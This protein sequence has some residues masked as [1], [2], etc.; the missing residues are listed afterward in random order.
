MELL[1][2]MFVWLFAAY[3]LLRFVMKLLSLCD[4]RKGTQPVYAHR[5]LAVRDCADSLEGL[6][7]SLVWSDLNEEVFVVNLGLDAETKLILQKLKIE[8]PFL[9]I[10]TPQQYIEYIQSMT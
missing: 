3:G 1:F 9:R 7:R 5:V 10:M 4:K 2:S 8:Y 6:V